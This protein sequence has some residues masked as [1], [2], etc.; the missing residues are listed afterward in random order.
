M[1]RT[2]TKHRPQ[3]SPRG[4]VC[5]LCSYCGV[6]WYRS[7][8]R[9]DRSGNLACP[10]EGDGLDVVALSEGNAEAAS[11]RRIGQPSNLV[12]CTFE[13]PN[14]VPSPGFVDP[15][16]WPRQPRGGNFG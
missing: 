10:D 15:N 3:S 1:S 16:G 14:T 12:D 9:R 8:L 7:Q 5:G 6:E 4:D 13:P 11:N 2:I